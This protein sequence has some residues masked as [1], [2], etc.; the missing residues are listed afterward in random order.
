MKP[1]LC[2]V[3]GPSGSG[4]TA[5][6]MAVQKKFPEF[7]TLHLDDYFFDDEQ[8]PLA[9]QWVNWELP[10]C[11]NVARLRED[12]A[13]LKA[14][15]RTAVVKLDHNLRRRTEI[16]IDPKPVIILEGTHALAFPEVRKIL[17]YGLYFVCSREKQM[18]RRRQRD[19]NLTLEYFEKVVSPAAFRY[20]LPTKQYADTVINSGR[21]LHKVVIELE[22]QLYIG[23]RFYKKQRNT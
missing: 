6:V 15:K 3:A 22:R 17:D 14:G 23:L 10:E 4:K 13:S 16:W 1:F 8:F 11:I 21:R 9:Y 12:L 18:K 5:A 19:P 20:I 7:L 2:A